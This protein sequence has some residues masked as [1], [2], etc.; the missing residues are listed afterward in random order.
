MR[1][2]RYVFWDVDDVLADTCTYTHSLVG[3]DMLPPSEWTSYHFGE[4]LA[5]RPTSHPLLQPSLSDEQR[6]AW[7]REQRL[8][9]IGVRSD[10]LA[11]LQAT[12]DLGY[13]NT[14]ITARGWNPT[15]SRITWEWVR[16]TGLARHVH[17]VV[18]TQSLECKTER[19]LQ[20][21][22]RVDLVALLVEDNGHNA[23]TAAAR[24]IPVAL[25]DHR[26]NRDV[27]HPNITRVGGALEA[28][29]LLA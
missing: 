4:H 2:P 24:G 19:I 10:A 18:I 12:D 14:L 9:D 1:S 27:T 17:S 15:A 11:A 22:S 16:S 5:A 20:L 13:I 3:E 7:L 23:L 25:V 26:W 6:E 28:A 21:L 29:H 8:Q